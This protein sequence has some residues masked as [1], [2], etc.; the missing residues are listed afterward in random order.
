MTE[1]MVVPTWGRRLAMAGVN[2]AVVIGVVAVMAAWAVQEKII[3]KNV[4]FAYK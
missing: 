3:M 4:F 1:K 2:G